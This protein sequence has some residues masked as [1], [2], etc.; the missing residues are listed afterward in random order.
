MKTLKD[1]L[2]AGAMVVALVVPAMALDLPKMSVVDFL[3]DAKDYAG[4]WVTVTDCTFL[5]LGS[6]LVYCYDKSELT[7]FFV[8]APDTLP[9]EDRKVLLS[10]CTVFP[11]P[12][13]VGDITGSVS[14]SLFGTPT[15]DHPAIEWTKKPNAGL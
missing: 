7:T 5:G 11:T 2:L 15:L 12:N 3:L 4:K 1:L 13:C 8:I 6:A 10:G 14:T 9:R